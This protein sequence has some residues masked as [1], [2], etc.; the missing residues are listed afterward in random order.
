[1]ELIFA[2]FDIIL[3][4]SLILLTLPKVRKVSIKWYI[5]N[6]LAAYCTSSF[7]RN[8]FNVIR[9]LVESNKRCKLLACFF[10]LILLKLY[11]FMQIIC[12]L[13]VEITFWITF[14]AKATSF[15]LILLILFF[16]IFEIYT[17]YAFKTNFLKVLYARL[18]IIE[19]RFLSFNIFRII[20]VFD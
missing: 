19:F 1:M 8:L 16:C 4:I 3:P 20:P 7:I 12:I 2:L 9:T 18:S 13:M 14:Y 15:A 10:K 11:A 5:I 17:I 6:L